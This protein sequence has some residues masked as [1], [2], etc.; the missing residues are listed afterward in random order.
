[1]IMIADIVK[2]IRIAAASVAV[3]DLKTALR[4]AGVLDCTVR[5]TMM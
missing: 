4:N 2:G 1:M 3:T 5:R